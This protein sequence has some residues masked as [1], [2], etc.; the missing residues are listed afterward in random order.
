MR[1][2]RALRPSKEGR[3]TCSSLSIAHVLCHLSQ[4]I[5]FQTDPVIIKKNGYS[6]TNIPVGTSKGNTCQDILTSFI[7]TVKWAKRNHDVNFF[8]DGVQMQVNSL[9]IF[10]Y[11]G[12][13]GGYQI[14]CSIA[15]CC[16]NSNLLWEEFYHIE[17]ISKSQFHTS[18]LL[19]KYLNSN[20]HHTPIDRPCAQQS[21]FCVLPVLVF[22]LFG[23]LPMFWFTTDLQSHV[24]RIGQ[25][26]RYFAYE[27]RHQFGEDSQ[28]D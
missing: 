16:T 13:H 1:S 25:V 8:P 24:V 17:R 15:S 7:R 21:S 10:H 20:L 9:H 18:V 2:C 27:S 19:I 6:R 11:K 12:A 3:C 14:S 22:Y 23:C 4:W 26:K 5:N 28:F